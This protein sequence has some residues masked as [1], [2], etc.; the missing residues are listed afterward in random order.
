MTF[1]IEPLRPLSLP[2]EGVRLI[3]A[4]AG[5]GKTW[6]IAALYVRA[7]LGHGVPQPLLPPQILVVTFTEAA[8][9]ELRERIRARLVEAAL[10]FR[11]GSAGEPLLAELIAAYDVGQHAAC[12]RRL[13]LAAQWMDEAAIFTI[14]GWSQR[15]LVQH[16]FGS[17]HAFAQTLEPD[18]SELLAECVRDYWRQAFYPL[19][20]Q[21][22]AAVQEKWRTPDAL[23]RSL[24]PLLGGGEATL[25]IDGEVLGVGDGLAATLAARRAWEDEAATRLDAA[26]RAWRSDVDAIEALLLEAATSK[27]LSNTKYKPDRVS[28]ELVGMRR[29]A[30]TGEPGGNE[31]GRYASSTLAEGTSKNRARPEHPAFG[32]LEHWHEWQASRI[33]IH[34][35]VLADALA[36]VRDRF[37]S[38]KRRRAQMGF[39][40]LLLR[41]DRSL[42]SASGAD[43]AATIRKQYPLA[44]IDEFQDTDPLQYR[45]F[46]AVYGGE[47]ETGLLLIG[48]PKQAIYAFRGADIHT[49][50]AARAEA[51][52]PHYS[53]DTNFRSTQ[54][55]VD[56]VNALFVH[57]EGHASGAFHFADRGLPF[58]PVLARGRAE[59]FLRGGAEQPALNLW[60]LDDE[61]PVGV[62]HYRNEMA[63]ACASEIVR[64]LDEAA[65]GEAGFVGPAGAMQPLR[66]ADIAVLVRSHAEATQVR[67]ALASRRVRSVFLSDRDSVWESV[68]AGDVLFWLR[69]VA[70]P[71]SDTAMRAALA[72]RTLHLGFAEL[73]RLNT[74]ERHWEARGQQ[75]FALRD[76]WRHAG[77]LAM[78]HRLL[79]VFDLPAR[80]LAMDHGERALTNVLHLAELLQQAAAT[81]DGEQALIRYLAERIADT[82]SHHGDDQIVRLESDDDLVKVITIHKSKGLEYPL[83]FLPFV[84]APTKGRGG[85]GYRYHDGE[86]MSLELGG[87]EGGE[88]VDAAKE[89][90]ERASLQEDLRVLYVA[91]TRARHACWLGIA[92]VADSSRIR[93]P[94]VHRSAFGHLL[95]GGVE[96]DNGEIAGLLQALANNASS[97]AVTYM[98][99][100]DDQRY[101]APPRDERMLPPRDPKLARAEPWRIAS[102]SGLRYAE[103]DIDVPAP[104][105]AIDD[106][107]V[108]YV[109]EPVAVVADPASIHAFHRGADAGTF[110][111]DLLEWIADEGF[112]SIANDPVRLRDTVARRC[113]RRGWEA[114]ID[115]LTD[116]L[117]V[118][119]H[120]PMAL[121]DGATVALAAFDDPGRYRAELEFLFEAR[122]VDAEALDRIVREHTLGGAPRPAL[123]SDTLN[124]MLKGF[125]DLIIE[126]DGRW[127]VADYKSNWL[128]TDEQAYTPEAMRASIL[129]S[130][131]EL[132]YALYLLALHRLLRS[133][134]GPAY[135]YDIHVGGAVYLYLRGVDGRGHGVHVERP[136]KA[137][138]DAM[139]R[140]FEGADA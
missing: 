90:A 127:Y 55:M 79:H 46:R 105:T 64:L 37:A 124:G 125:I 92:P 28:R 69:A 87:G 29:W 96:I 8:T 94:Q 112:A 1:A 78:L 27:A 25:R 77:T 110:L 88:A 57:G 95:K 10:A 67:A 24:K 51:A 86:G 139:D 91:M 75:F 102:Y 120:T 41:L 38:Q 52:A 26:A 63:A 62:R 13:E 134:L 81:L 49:Y 76:T 36:W 106:V 115:L 9:Q 34:H 22:L 21:T 132:Q 121:P 74:D 119:L 35:V 17:G 140:L 122:R 2:L 123:A 14:H 73:E 6:T 104:E 16:A 47:V 128:G 60:L 43:L 114:S 137:M 72:T 66:P 68:E 12:A 4:S 97:V 48:D 5:T 135:D 59:R 83:V 70:E 45:I 54:G 39:D 50:L 89:A 58:A 20:E 113:E 31:L 44:L 131:Y 61:Q 138:I 40:D 99:A 116:W 98:P 117:L 84:A 3:E 101:I 30:Q 133:R 93:K 18:E 107:I 82:A 11:A 65:R 53:L 15:M 80:L 19:D 136:P 100:P 32:A 23:L 130:R 126:H 108:E 103:A 85:Q 118:L 129:D 42:A 33:A 71:S 111:H 109:T 7:V 56:A